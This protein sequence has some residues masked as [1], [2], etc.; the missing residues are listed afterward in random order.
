[1]DALAKRLGRDEG[2]A[3]IVEFALITPALMVLMMG[4]FDLSYNMYTNGMLHGAI[5]QAARNSTIEGAAGSQLVIDAM[6][7][8]AVKAV[9]PQSTIVASRRAYTSFADVNRP[10]DYVDDNDNSTCDDGEAYEDANGNGKWDSVQGS[11]GFGSA[12]DVVLYTVTVTYPRA[13]PIAGLIPGQTNSYTLRSS[14]VLRNQPYGMQGGD[15]KPTVG[16]CT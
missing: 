16:N 8:K 6:V 3:T 2:G 14:T 12:R 5:Q 1:M 10:E 4:L 13:F 15:T 9:A 7:E 11:A